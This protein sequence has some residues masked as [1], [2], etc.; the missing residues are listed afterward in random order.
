MNYPVLRSSEVVF[1]GV[2]AAYVEYAGAGLSPIAMRR[3]LTPRTHCA[4]SSFDAISPACSGTGSGACLPFL[5]G[6]SP[7][8]R[9]A[10]IK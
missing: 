3:L 5:N 4:S 9:R 10:K 7:F 1:G 2:C 6:L 8:A